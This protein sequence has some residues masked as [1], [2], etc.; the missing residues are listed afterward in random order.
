MAVVLDDQSVGEDGGGDFFDVVGVDGFGFVQ[1]GGGLG[2]AHHGEGGACGEGATAAIGAAQAFADKG[3][4]AA[5]AVVDG[6]GSGLGLGGDDFIGVEQGP[7]FL[8]LGAALGVELEQ[9]GLGFEVRQG[10]VDA[11]QEAVELRLGQGEGAGGE[12]VVLGGDD[13]EGRVQAAGDA[14]D[15]DLLFA[16]TLEKGTLDAGAGPVDFVG[17]DDVAEDRARDELKL[18]GALMVDGIAGDVGRQEV[19]GEL[20]AAEGGIDAAGEGGGEAGFPDAGR[21]LDQDVAIGEQG[22]DEEKGGGFRAEDGSRQALVEGVKFLSHGLAL[23]E[24][25]EGAAGPP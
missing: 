1:P 10:H 6:D 23:G 25:R 16:H 20:D 3:D 18:A 21:A 22:G 4:I 12:Q 11:E 13:H 8:E 2:G 5:D 17:E 14:V 7:G 9:S 15:R 24:R 19:R